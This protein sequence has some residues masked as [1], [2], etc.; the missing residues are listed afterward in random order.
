MRNLQSQLSGTYWNRSAEPSNLR[1]DSE[2]IPEPEPPT[3]PSV[4]FPYPREQQE[5]E[6]ARSRRRVTL[7]RNLSIDISIS[8]RTESDRLSTLSPSSQNFS[9]PLVSPTQETTE[10]PEV[11]D[12]RVATTIPNFKVT[13][14]ALKATQNDKLPK[15]TKLAPTFDKDAPE[16]LERF[17]LELEDLFQNNEITLDESKILLALRYMEYKTGVLHDDAATACGGSWETFKKLL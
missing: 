12:A 14:A 17:F 9:T 10:M 8:Q 6:E 1:I 7:G 3:N 13:E 16:L 4:Y 5:R 2:Q 11:I 15:P